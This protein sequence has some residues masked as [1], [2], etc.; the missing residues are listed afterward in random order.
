MED[1]GNNNSE[2]VG[3]GKP[4]KHSQFSKGKSG[5]KKGRPK[6]SKNIGS[7]FRNE[8]SER[9]PITEN[10]KHRTITKLEATIKQVVNK[11]I[12][13]PSPATAHSAHAVG[14]HHPLHKPRQS[15]VTRG[16]REYP[17]MEPRTV[18]ARGPP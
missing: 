6:S 13:P 4:P 15:S 5:N 1:N 7:V 2:S 17:A 18:R 9:I 16:P 11:A 14:P 10:G 3:Y 12:Q 8:L